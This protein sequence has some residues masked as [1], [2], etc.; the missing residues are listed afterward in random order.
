MSAF[1]DRVVGAL[2]DLREDVA[3]LEVRMG[4][5]Y[6]HLEA[7]IDGLY[8]RRRSPPAPAEALHANP[9]AT[10]SGQYPAVVMPLPAARGPLP[11]NPIDVL[12][13]LDRRDLQE[14]REQLRERRE[15]NNKIAVGVLLALL[16]GVAGVL[17]W[18][19]PKALAQPTTPPALTR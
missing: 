3:R 14:A 19:L 18:S 9:P 15:L 5:R 16:A 8:D 10:T 12:N 6:E 11:S 2:G 4:E 1:E 17:A 13:E 7:R